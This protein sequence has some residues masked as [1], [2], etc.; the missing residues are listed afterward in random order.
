MLENKAED[1]NPRE[2]SLSHWL[3]P[4]SSNFRT[5]LWPEPKLEETL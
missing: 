1:Q 3:V 4:T 5:R 2:Q